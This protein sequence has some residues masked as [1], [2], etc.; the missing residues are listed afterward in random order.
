VLG[1]DGRK[2]SKQE[3][4]LAVDVADPL[5]ALRAALAFLGQDVAAEPTVDAT[6]AAALARFDARRIPASARAPASF[7]ALRKDV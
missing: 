6:L 1:E 5:P 2:L 7:A 4:A 3:R